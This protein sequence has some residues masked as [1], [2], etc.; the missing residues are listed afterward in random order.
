[1]PYGQEN[2]DLMNE[3]VVIM[4]LEE[5]QAHYYEW[6]QLIMD[7]ILPLLPFYSP[8]AYTA[9][10]SNLQGYDNRWGYA[11]SMPYMEYD[12]LHTGQESVTEFIDSDAKWKELNPLLQDDASSSTI[13]TMMMEPILQMTPGFEAIKTGLIV[14][15][16][17]DE[18]NEYLYKFTMRDDVY[19][20]P[21]YNITGR[22]GSS[23]A[24]DPGTTPLMV[25]IKGEYSDGT[26]QKV[27]AKD[28]VFTYLAWANGIVSE[29]PEGFNWIKN[30]W[31]DGDWET[32]L[33]FNIEIDGNPATPENDPYA[34][35]WPSLT[36]RC[37]PEFFLNSTNVTVVET[38]GGVEHIGIGAG[39]L[40][41]D[42]WKTFSTSAFGCGKFMLDYYVEGSVTV[43]QASPY[44]MEIGAIDG[45]A[46]DLDITTF[47]MRVIPDQTAALAEFKAGKLSIMGLTLF[48]DDRKAMQTDPDF[49]VQ[50][51]LQS[52]FNFFGFNLR[53]PFIGGD[54]N[55][56]FL[57]QAGYEEYTKAIAVRKLLLTQ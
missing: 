2:E 43:M 35:F 10:W 8:R 41:T 12:G 34:P 23:A 48:P 3:G 42:Q 32:S 1:M 24:L 45:T 33:V 19:W 31:I 6:Q 29:D 20:N 28:A 44:W 15:W 40:S 53:R 16:E 26:N 54:D 13:S 17:Q 21:S 22:T 4:D 57:E 36:Y 50:T 49:T 55:Y 25:G 47:I 56:E 52:Y 39:I 37:L 38:S 27:T 14:D 46:Q 30:I 11:D 5:R 51:R 18:T 9:T 7:K